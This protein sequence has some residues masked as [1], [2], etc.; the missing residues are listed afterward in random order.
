MKLSKLFLSAICIALPLAVLAA[1]NPPRQ[2][3]LTLSV[4]TPGRATATETTAA[5]LGQNTR[6]GGKARQFV[7]RARWDA[8]GRAVEEKETLY[9]GLSLLITPTA[10]LDD[11]VV[12][13]VSAELL[14]LVAMRQ[15]T[16]QGSRVELP[17]TRMNEA[18]LG[19]L[20][21]KYGELTPVSLFNLGSAG[22]RVVHLQA[23]PLPAQP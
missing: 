12:V 18:S 9:E 21:L 20:V 1:D 23:K 8:Q 16:V 11:R 4:L 17:V 6:I 22:G 7:A 13:S 5:S 19:N 10:V 14:D 2:V 15:E 3:E